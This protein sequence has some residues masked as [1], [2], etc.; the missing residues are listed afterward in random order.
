MSIPPQERSTGLV[1]TGEIETNTVVCANNKSLR[2]IL[3]PGFKKK[4][5]LRMNLTSSINSIE[6][7][8][9]VCPGYDWEKKKKNLS[10]L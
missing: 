1:K 6:Q 3:W 4:I 10:A 9:Q 5:K 2:L 7:K 8:H